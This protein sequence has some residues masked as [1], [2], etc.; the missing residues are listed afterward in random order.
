MA[1]IM[2]HNV[3][4]ANI[5]HMFCKSKA[6]KYICIQSLRTHFKF[7]ATQTKQQANVLD[8]FLNR[9]QDILKKLIDNKPKIISKGSPDRREID[10]KGVNK[11]LITRRMNVLNKQLMHCISDVLSTEEIGLKIQKLQ[12][13]ITQVSET[14]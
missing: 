9:N 4:N 8:K 14:P 11:R 12:V 10:S 5:C 6:L 1:T 7:S 13:R 2:A 3:L